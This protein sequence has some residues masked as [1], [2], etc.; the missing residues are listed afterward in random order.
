M[1]SAS[2]A[3]RAGLVTVPVGERTEADVVAQAIVATLSPREVL[4]DVDRKRSVMLLHAI[5]A[6]DPDAIREEHDRFY[7][8]YQR[9]CSRK[10]CTRTP[11]S[12]L[13]W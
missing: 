10:P 8:R 13:A 6:S 11:R 5:D 1:V 4:V 12:S 3:R 9:T 7:C 2:P